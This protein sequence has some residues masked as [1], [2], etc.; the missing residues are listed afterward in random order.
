[1][2][3]LRI[4]RKN[5]IYNFV[6]FMV[7]ITL[8]L[9]NYENVDKMDAHFSF[10]RMSSLINDDEKMSQETDVSKANNSFW[11]TSSP[12]SS[13]SNNGKKRSAT[14]LIST[15]SIIPTI[16]TEMTCFVPDEDVPLKANGSL[17]ILELK[18][19]TNRL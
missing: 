18:T 19:S 11:N 16:N 4:C 9:D 12:A 7:I 5:P 8:L 14:E 2:S 13:S 15:S 6:H 17:D 3:D 1:M 10:Y